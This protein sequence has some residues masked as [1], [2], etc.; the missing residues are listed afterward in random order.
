[1]TAPAPSP[2]P[3]RPAPL[4]PTTRGLLVW[5]LGLGALAVTFFVLVSPLAWPLKIATWVALAYIAD[6]V[7]GWFGYTAAALGVLPYLCGP[8][9][10]I[11]FGAA[12]IP[13]WNVL[14]PL[15]FTAL[16]AAFLVK[17]SGGALVLPVSLVVFAA[18][19][20]L[21]AKIAPLLD[22]TVTLPTNRTLLMHACGAAVFGTILS[23][24]RRAVAAARR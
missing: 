16:L 14:F 6:E 4:P 13:Q 3:S 11:T 18:P 1:M 23:F 20:L 22:A 17:H 19:F 24:A 10:L 8:E 5:A 15:V 12:P 2:T 9:G 21:A 7:S